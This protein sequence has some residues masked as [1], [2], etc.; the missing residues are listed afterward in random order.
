MNA[1]ILE[2][3]G[4][5]ASGDATADTQASVAAITALKA[6]KTAGAEFLAGMEV[7]S[8]DLARAKITG[9]V[10]AAD[11]QTA[12]ATIRRTAAETAVAS[13]MAAE[14]GKIAAVNQEWATAFHMRDPEGFAA[15]FAAAPRVIPA[16]AS[17]VPA[18]GAA[19][20]EKGA[21]WKRAGISEP[22]YNG[23]VADFGKEKADA[24]CLELAEGSKPNTNAN[25]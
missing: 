23:L 16:G 24:Q 4:L 10:P 19:T 12:Q 5:T 6:D 8:F 20:D 21:C 15:H 3:L 9:L 17:I 11:L 7:A 14:S 22:E 2:L 18:P 1:E 13:L 25:A